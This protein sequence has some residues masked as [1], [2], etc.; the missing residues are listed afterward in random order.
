MVL[1]IAVPAMVVWC[2]ARLHRARF[3]FSVIS[4]IPVL[5]LG[6]AQGVLV[7]SVLMPSQAQVL[8]VFGLTLLGCVTAARTAAYEG[9]RRTR[10]RGNLVTPT[11]LVGSGP[12]ASRIRR[13]S[14]EKPDYGIDV[15]GH[16]EETGD[17]ATRVVG[18]GDNGLAGTLAEQDD[19]SVIVADRIGMS[20]E[21]ADLLRDFH[22]HGLDTYVASPLGVMHT[23][24]AQDD[25]IDGIVLHRVVPGYQ[26]RIALLGKRGFDLAVA[27]L[28]L[29]AIAPVLA[30]VT[31]A[32]RL[33]LG[34]GVVFRQERVGQHGRIFTLFKFR[35]MP[36]ADTQRRWGSAAVDSSIGPVGRFIRRTSLDELLQLVNVVNGDMSLV[37]PRPEQEAFTREFACRFAGYELRHRMP[38]GITGLA[39]VEGM[40]GNTSLEDRVHFDNYYIENWSPWLDGRIL[41]RT[42]SEVL[43]GGGR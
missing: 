35:S 36:H 1:T 16:L 2:C 25:D 30:L 22:A 19:V 41:L 3:R 31:I 11:I 9:F 37:G 34:P 18:Q 38:V 6:V 15:I 21:L 32:V 29:L 27:G 39:A 10:R 43:G 23:P 14:D 13:R 26:R 42:V 40:R 8:T 24:G 12:L 7:A 5:V 33:E 17:G 4:D 28:I 20:A